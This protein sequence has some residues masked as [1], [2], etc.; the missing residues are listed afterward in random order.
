M[1]NLDLFVGILAEPPVR[2]G[3]VGELGARIIGQTFKN[4]RD[5]DRL[6]YENAYSDSIINEID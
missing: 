6:W 1:D 3:V 4:L 2:N 5:G